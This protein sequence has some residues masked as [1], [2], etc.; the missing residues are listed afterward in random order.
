MRGLKGA[1]VRDTNRQTI[2]A[3]STTVTGPKTPGME[4]KDVDDTSLQRKTTRRTTRQGGWL[5]VHAPLGKRHISFGA[6]FTRSKGALIRDNHDSDVLK[7]LLLSPHYQAHVQNSW[8]H[9][10]HPAYN[11]SFLRDG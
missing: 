3:H 5:V 10:G 8:R 6:L 2:K 9:S 4:L 11:R 7:L 1:L